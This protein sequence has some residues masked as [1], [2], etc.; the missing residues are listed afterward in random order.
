MVAVFPH[1]VMCIPAPPY[2][3]CPYKGTTYGGQPTSPCE[4]RFYQPIAEPCFAHTMQTNQQTLQACYN[5][6]L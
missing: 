6:P 1:L 5:L 2:I 3:L 4:I